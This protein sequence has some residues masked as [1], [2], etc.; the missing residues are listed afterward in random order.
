M[1]ILSED[2]HPEVEA[3]LLA[4]WRQM[5]PH[6]KLDR[7]FRMRETV[8]SFAMAGLRM[9]HPDETEPQLRRRLA[10]LLVGEDLAARAYGPVEEPGYAP[11]ST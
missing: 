1:A 4:A 3:L 2:T 5:T 10:A 9:R 7:V 6:E 8:V 11:K